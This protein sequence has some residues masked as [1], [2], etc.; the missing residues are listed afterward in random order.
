MDITAVLILITTD[1]EMKKK[2]TGIAMKGLQHDRNFGGR[3]GRLFII[4]PSER[5]NHKDCTEGIVVNKDDK[6]VLLFDLS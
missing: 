2:N 1:E 5:C 3:I 6:A 4:F